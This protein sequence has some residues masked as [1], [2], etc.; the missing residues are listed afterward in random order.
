MKTKTYKCHD[1]SFN[2]SKM[3]EDT[4]F[5]M[6]THYCGGSAS[7]SKTISALIE[8]IAHLRG[9]DVTKWEARESD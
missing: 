3:D 6:W 4:L 9:F 7:E 2:F 1:V 5:R 8:N